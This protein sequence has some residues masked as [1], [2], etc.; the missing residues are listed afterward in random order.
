LKQHFKY[1]MHAILTKTYN[2]QQN[3]LAATYNTQ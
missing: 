3:L 1:E 2:T